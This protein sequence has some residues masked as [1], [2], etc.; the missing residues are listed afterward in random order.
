MN[1]LYTALGLIK[2]LNENKKIDSKKVSEE[3]GVSIRTAQRYLLELSI[4]PGVVHN[5]KDNSYSLIDSYS[6]EGTFLSQT[7]LSYVGALFDFLKRDVNNDSAKY[8]D[9]LKSKIFHLNG[10]T[11]SYDFVKEN[12]IGFENISS[13]LNDLEIAIKEQNEITFF[14]ERYSRNY[15]VKPYR[16]I[17]SDGFWYLLGDHEDCLKKFVV[18]QISEIKT[19]GNVFSHRDDIDE[20]IKDANNIWFNEHD[21]DKITMEID[22]SV[23]DYFK[24]KSCLT[25]QKITGE[26]ES[27]IEVTFEVYN[28]MDFLLQILRWAPFIKIKNPDYY[29]QTLKKY[30]Q[31]SLE[32]MEER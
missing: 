9:K 6:F 29:K 25:N 17:L 8:L 2:L 3:L 24:R 23:A 19:T 28:E 32:K 30:L 1:K 26:G 27:S 10:I 14:Y 16:I 13:V 22:N 7:E 15:T 4:I 21:K 18:D 11:F 31:D 5:E 20:I 12:M